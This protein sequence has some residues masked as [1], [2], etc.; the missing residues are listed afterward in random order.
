MAL[1]KERKEKYL[2]KVI[3]A[4]TQQLH[5]EKTQAENL[6]SPITLLKLL[7]NL[8]I[9]TRSYQLETPNKN[10]IGI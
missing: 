6:L 1:K 2:S 7:N 10:N 3:G 9:D 4:N 5:R 8:S